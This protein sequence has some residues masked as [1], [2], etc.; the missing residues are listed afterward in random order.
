MKKFRIEIIQELEV[1]DDCT[2]SQSGVCPC[3]RFGGKWIAPQAEYLQVEAGPNT[4]TSR[5][6]PL[7]EDL[8]DLLMPCLAK[9]N[10]TITEIK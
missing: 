9:D 7:D 3:L 6:L 4:T 5:L 10:V 2:V 1:P 8:M